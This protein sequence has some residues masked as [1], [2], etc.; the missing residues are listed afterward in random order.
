[1]PSISRLSYWYILDIAL[2]TSGFSGQLL[3]FSLSTYT[4]DH[5]GAKIKVLNQMVDE[6][7]CA[8]ACSKLLSFSPLMTFHAK[9]YL[10]SK[11]SR[12]KHTNKTVKAL[13]FLVKD[14][15]L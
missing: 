2:H 5:I 11:M 13:H 1:M 4:A 8:V 7:N 15:S 10:Q 6:P 14:G 12:S 3:S 9:N